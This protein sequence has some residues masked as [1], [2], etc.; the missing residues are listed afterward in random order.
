MSIAADLA[1]CGFTEWAAGGGCVALR[2]EL[3]FGAYILATDLDGGDVAELP[4][5]WAVGLYDANAEALALFTCDAN[6]EMDCLTAVGE[7]LDVSMG[8]PRAPRMAAVD[9]HRSLLPNPLH[10]RLTTYGDGFHVTAGK[11][12]VSR[13]ATQEAAKRAQYLWVATGLPLSSIKKGAA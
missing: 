4:D 7:C 11:G 1:A 3:P 9:F 10:W 2:R 5:D 8:S 13:Y 12:H 6:P